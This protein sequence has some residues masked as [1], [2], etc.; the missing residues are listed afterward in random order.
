MNDTNSRATPRNPYLFVVGCLRSGT[1]M[2]QRML[3]AHPDLAVGYDSHFIPRPIESLPLGVDPPLTDDLV[4]QAVGH[5]RFAKLGLSPSD[6][7]TARQASSTYAEFV[8][9]LYDAFARLHGKPLAGEKSPGYC[10]HLPHLHGLFPWARTIHLFR[11]GRDIALSVLDWGKGPK[12]LELARREPVAACA[13]WWRRDVAA[14]R[15]YGARLGPDRFREVRYEDLVAAPEPMLRD[16]AGWL[17]LPYDDRMARYHEGKTRAGRTAKSSWIEPTAGLRNWREQMSARDVELFE[18][19]AGGALEALGYERA[20]HRAAPSVRRIAAE[21]EEWWR[22]SM[23]EPPSWEE[24]AAPSSSPVARAR[25]RESGRRGNPFVFFVGCPRSGTTLLKRIAN[26]HRD[27]A[28]TP[29][30]HWIPRFHRR[31]IGVDDDG[32][33]TPAMLSALA[34]HPKFENLRIDLWRVAAAIEDEPT[35]SELVTRIFD[36]Y[37]R[38]QGKPLV[39]DKTPGYVKHIDLLHQLWPGARFAHLVRDGRDVCLS[40]LEW[41]RAARNVGRLPTWSED[42]VSTAAVWWAGMVR[43]GRDAFARLPAG[44]GLELR[45]EALIADPRR[46]CERLCAFLELPFDPAMMTFHQGRTR[47]EEGLSAKK[48]W[49]PPTAGLRDWRTQMSAEA[50]ER[51]ES[52]AGDLLEELGYARACPAPSARAVRQ[53]ARIVDACAREPSG[54]EPL[55]T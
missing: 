37:G 9:R 43:C 46:E 20:T 31:A 40:L 45:Y 16:L 42:R 25:K 17:E 55:R 29:E 23:D 34:G 39:G 27:L 52:V 24:L 49:L 47:A 1:T 12:K 10:R 30:T 13:L 41:S 11:D 36:L 6:V 2:L 14:A 5:R 19:L 38:A 8:S 18:A 32:R 28:V 54:A 22:Q 33:V 48:A 35:Y 51:F 3:D 4:G 7:E 21:C 53:A 26:A 44:L 50:V 15:A